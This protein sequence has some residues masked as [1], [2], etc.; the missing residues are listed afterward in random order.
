M[1]DPYKI[2]P[3]DI[4][5][6]TVK[7]LLEVDSA[8]EKRIQAIAARDKDRRSRGRSAPNTSDVPNLSKIGVAN[9]EKKDPKTEKLLKKVTK[10]VKPASKEE[11]GEAAEAHGDTN[12]S[13]SFKSYLS[14]LKKKGAVSESTATSTAVTHRKEKGTDDPPSTKG[15]SEV[16]TSTSKTY[17][18]SGEPRKAAH[19]TTDDQRK[20]EASARDERA[21]VRAHKERMKRMEKLGEAHSGEYQGQLDPD[22][23]KPTGDSEEARKMRAKRPPISKPTPAQIA[24]R[25]E[26][27]DEPDVGYHADRAKERA[28]KLKLKAPNTGTTRKW[29]KKATGRGESL[30][31]PS[32]KEKWTNPFVNP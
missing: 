26:V 14:E 10:G 25:K 23:G 32:A 27:R 28:R 31:E 4:S 12:E 8:T 29:T 5:G 17:K 22:E 30:P 20:R 9:K 15:T 3:N 21:K 18:T 6:E 11:S 7:R 24:A 19:F 2:E 13:F 1:K 16:P